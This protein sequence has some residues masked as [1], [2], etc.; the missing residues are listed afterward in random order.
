VKHF[1]LTFCALC[2]LAC[3]AMTP[4][5]ASA[6][7][8]IEAQSAATPVVAVRDPQSGL[9]R[10]AT[11]AEIRALNGPAM[12]ARP[13]PGPVMLRGDGR[14]Q[15]HLGDAGLVHVLVQRNAGGALDM[16]CSETEAPGADA[17]AHHDR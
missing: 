10:P 16:R 14:R 5:R 7:A 6:Q 3:W 9:L 13:A 15:V 1:N 11:P 2:A 4:G 8:P 12:A 17:G